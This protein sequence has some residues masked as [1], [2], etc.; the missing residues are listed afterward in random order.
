MKL[1]KKL[2]YNGRNINNNNISSFYKTNRE[3]KENNFLS[4]INNITRKVEFLNTKNDILSDEN[5]M[6]Q[7][8]NEENDE[9]NKLNDFIKD[10]YSMKKF[11]KSIFD[12][13]KGSKYLMPIF[14]SKLLNLNNINKKIKNNKLN[15]HENEHTNKYTKIKNN[16]KDFKKQII[17]LYSKKKMEEKENDLV[18]VVIFPSNDETI[19]S[20]FPTKK[21][22][23]SSYDKNNI[24]NNINLNQENNISNLILGNA[25]TSNNNSNYTIPI[26]NIIK[27]PRKYEEYEYKKKTKKNTINII[28]NQHR[29]D[30]I[31]EKMKINRVKKKKYSIY[32]EKELH[33]E[34]DDVIIN[35]NLNKKRVSQTLNNFN[36]I[37]KLTIKKNNVKSNN[38][39]NIENNRNKITNIFKNNNEKIKKVLGIYKDNKKVKYINKDINKFLYRKQNYFPKKYEN[40]KNNLSYS[41]DDDSENSEDNEDS[42][43][44]E[45][46]N[47]EDINENVSEDTSSFDIEK[48]EEKLEKLKSSSIKESNYS[49][50]LILKKNIEIEE[51]KF[52]SKIESKKIKTL[53][54]LFQY[55]KINLREIIKKENIINLLN[56][57]EF[58]ENVDLLKIQIT[59]SR[60]LSNKNHS[61]KIKPVTDEDI[62]NYLYKE[63]NK[64]E[65]SFSKIKFFPN[66]KNYFTNIHL[67][68]KN[69]Q[70]EINTQ[71]NKEIINE[72]KKIQENIEKE[73]EKEKEKLKLMVNE[74]ELTKE[75]KLHILETNNKEFRER[76]QKILQQIESYQNLDMADYV[77]AIK[78][79]YLALKDEMNQILSDKEMEERING[80]L[81]NLDIERNILDSK[82]NFFNDK[83]NIKDNKFHSYMEN[84]INQINEEE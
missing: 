31:I 83:L 46:F 14:N 6:N 37:N 29:K 26:Q 66:R 47:I 7:L 57:K 30:Y 79:N 82:W 58:R 11:S 54:L 4:L 39:I 43:S 19:Q 12:E 80:F 76:F 71:I 59:K 17:K 41:N 15:F 51:K 78:R 36:E 16:N 35:L 38:I 55:I 5:T 8:N 13:K 22:I 75:L 34:N 73:R 69:E 10:N 44:I 72:N 68:K 56:E 60:E 45:N 40:K 50:M 84:N 49:N 65:K 3:E 25:K 28:D 74:M 42:L 23:N 27:S 21:I 63:I 32:N 70:N 64:N 48:E 9:Y 67:K 20:E 18:N 1:K 33:K 77:E 24:L 81:T 52:L 61:K 62:I 2:F 53:K